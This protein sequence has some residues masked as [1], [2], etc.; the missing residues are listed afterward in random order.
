[1]VKDSVASAMQ[2][3]KCRNRARSEGEQA[4]PQRVQDR[5]DARRKQRVKP[6]EEQRVR[7]AC[8]DLGGADE[9]ARQQ[10]LR[11]RC[12]G[13]LQKPRQM[14]R[15]RSG[16]RPACRKSESKQ[17]HCAI[18]GQYRR[19]GPAINGG[20]AFCVGQARVERNANEEM[21]ERPAKAGF[22]PAQII[23][24]PS[25]QR[26]SNRACEAGHQ[27]DGGNRRPRGDPIK[28]GER[29]ESRIV[30]ARAHADSDEEPRQT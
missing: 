20:Q 5:R 16:D 22:A 13:R 1:M 7:K 3:D 2:Q 24:A 15:H 12:A 23:Q 29:R 26:P 27:G 14:G 6:L 28:A 9:N 30:E 10:G 17:P 25:R 19:F 4:S 8:G 18:K 11:W 21:G